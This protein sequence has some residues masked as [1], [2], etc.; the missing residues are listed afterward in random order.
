MQVSSEIFQNQ[1]GEVLQLLN[2]EEAIQ[3][4][5]DSSLIFAIFLY[6]SM[7]A[8]SR[9]LFCILNIFSKRMLKHQIPKTGLAEDLQWAIT[10]VFKM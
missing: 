1:W 10:K 8:F 3:M 2:H 9:N 7:V 4:L 5:R 6:F